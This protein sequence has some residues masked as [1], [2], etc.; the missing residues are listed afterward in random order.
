[1][2]LGP[3]TDRRDR[4]P[5][6]GDYVTR[7]RNKRSIDARPG[8][9]GT[10]DPPSLVD[11]ADGVIESFPCRRDR[12][13]G[14]A[15]RRCPSATPKLVYGACGRLRPHGAGPYV[16]AGV[17]RGR[18]G[19]GRLRRHDRPDTRAPPAHGPGH[20][21]PRARRDGG[22]RPDRRAP[23]RAAR[24]EGQFVD[25]AM[26]DVLIAVCE[27]MTWRYTY[28]GEIQ[29]PR[30]AEHPSRRPFELQRRCG[31]SGGHRCAGRAALAAAVR[32]DLPARDGGTDERYS[33]ARRRVEHRGQVRAAITV[34]SGSRTL[35]PRSSSTLRRVPCGPVNNAADLADDPHARARE[36]Y[37]AI[38]HPGSARPVLTLNTPSA[39]PRRPAPWS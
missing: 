19:H 13:R 36:M 18:P 10:G 7:N 34:W 9:Q 28:T 14:S 26:V 24:G 33:S 3:P 5:T 39:S 32:H 1:M 4:L 38:S 22:V 20:R 17:R 35:V 21:R 23:A 25:V 8:D 31:W 16:V 27:L 11:T 29:A 2:R 12:A 15:T 37:V 6:A 30:G